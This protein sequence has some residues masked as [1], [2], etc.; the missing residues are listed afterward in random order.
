MIIR[1][2]RNIAKR[3]EISGTTETHL[4]AGR[5]LIAFSCQIC[6]GNPSESRSLEVPPY[7]LNTN[8][9]EIWERHRKR[10]LLIW[11]DPEGRQ[12]GSSG[13]CAEGLRGAG[14][15]GLP[16]WAEIEFDGAKLPKFDKGWPA[17]IKKIYRELKD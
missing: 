5:C 11:K 13:F 12:P 16:C 2:R 1:T 3:R 10:L 17:D 9:R 14:R 15:L 7:T 4:L 6:S 8:A